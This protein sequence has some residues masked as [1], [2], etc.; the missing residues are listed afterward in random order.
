MS[1][2]VR[3][4][5]VCATVCFLV[6]GYSLF[7]LRHLARSLG[8]DEVYY[9]HWVDSWDHQ[10]VHYPHHL[11]FVPA[12]VFF[13]RQFS[14][15]TGITNTAFIQKLKNILAVSLALGL[16]FLLFYRH[17]G[18]YWLSLLFA[19]LIGVSGALWH[20]AHHHETSAIPGVLINLTVLLLLF[21]RGFPHPSL[22]IA[23]LAALT[24]FAILLHQVYLLSLVAVFFTLLFTRPHKDARFSVSKN[25]LRSSLYL[26]L[27]L[28]L[29]GGVY[30]YIGFVKLGLRLQDNPQGTQ[31]LPFFEGI[32]IRGNFLRFF[33]LI[34]AR[35]K[36]GK[37]QP[38]S[39]KQAA[40]GYGA[41]FMTS[42]ATEK[43]NLRDFFAAEHFPSNAVSV[44]LAAFLSS[45]AF[46]FVPL[47]RRYG[48][49]YPGLLL[50][51]AAG[52]A[53]IYWWEP[54]YIEHWIYLTILTWALV[55]LVSTTL[56]EGARPGLPRAA[57]YLALCLLLLSLAAV[58]YRENL[59][60]T[61]LPQQRFF[62]PASVR[63]AVWSE[64]YR[65]EEMYR[66]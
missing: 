62:L 11:L 2:A 47:F 61:I 54:G 19:L 3:L 17:C 29:V 30:S 18:R 12:S 42:F 45:F 37:L 6:S 44:A 48:M 33:Y 56:I 1:K 55:F 36:W 14:A 59:T 28:A 49:L 52:S 41:S 15:L 51:L 4:L 38:S 10:P 20:D 64:E 65:M 27:V 66:R 24:A 50:W 8:Y 5:V 60:H 39:L 63:G 34:Q 21:Y 22:F 43:V 9:L 32:P 31:R 40:N 26:L 23:S 35:G 46:L 16:F 13:Q 53:F 58:V 7:N 57:V 25:L